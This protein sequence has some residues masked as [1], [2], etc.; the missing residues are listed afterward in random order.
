MSQKKRTKKMFKKCKIGIKFQKIGRTIR[1]TMKEN[2]TNTK[3]NANDMNFFFKNN[4][5]QKKKKK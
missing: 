3:N 1:I 2:E 5:M 4:K